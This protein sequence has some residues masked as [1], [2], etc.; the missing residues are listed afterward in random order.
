[1]RRQI[2]NHQKKVWN[3][4]SGLTFSSFQKSY[5]PRSGGESSNMTDSNVNLKWLSEECPEFCIP[6]KSIQ[7]LKEPSEFFQKLKEYSTSAKKRITL[8]SLYI[9][10]GV[11]EK[12]LVSCIQNCLDVSK[13]NVKVHILVDYTRGSRGKENTRTL[14]LPLLKLY[15]PQ[16]KVSLYHTPKLRG[17][18]KWLLPERWNETIGLSHLKV[19]LFDDTLLLSGANL[20][21]QYFTNRQ[22]RYIV[23]HNCKELCN[24]F[25]QLVFTVSSFSFNLNPDNTVNLQD[26]WNIHPI[27]GNFKKFIEKAQS[28]LEE[29]IQ[30]SKK[31]QSSNSIKNTSDFQNDTFVY[32]LLQL[33]T[34]GIRQ[35]EKVTEKFLCSA[36]DSSRIK[37]ASGYFNLTNHYMNIILNSTKA[38]FDLL[39]A[40]P[41]VNGFYGASGVSGA[42]PM[43]YTHIAKTFFKE[44]IKNKQENRIKLHEYE[45]SGWTFHVKGLWYYKPNAKLPSVT[46]IGS[47]NFGY[48]SVYKDLEAQVVIVTENKELQRQLHEVNR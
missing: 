23:F 31:Q 37:L 4:V 3:V 27:K 21:D 18:I 48:R 36:E 42:I 34:F 9:G 8:A 24:Y 29:F 32:P 5:A 11:L 43:A 7:I 20:S 15:H 28:K 12:E 26:G 22:D 45:R 46:F 30:F 40:S 33:Y 41:K 25:D 47:P 1:M 2:F 19:Y 16:M 44:V 10:T 17:F 13:G 38:L 6:S 14:F 39:V 35:D